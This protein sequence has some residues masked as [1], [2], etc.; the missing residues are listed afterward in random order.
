MRAEHFIIK[1]RFAYANN[2]PVSFVAITAGE[3]KKA[4]W[5]VGHG[6]MDPAGSCARCGRTLTH[7]GSILIGIGPE[8]LGNWGARDA[9]L[10]DMT[11]QDQVYLKSLVTDR[12]VDKW[13]PKAAIKS[14][15]ATDET[16]T[17]PDDHRS[18]TPKPSPGIP[19]PQGNQ[20]VTVAKEGTKRA[21]EWKGLIAIQFPYSYET[22][23]QVKQ[24]EGR[25]YHAEGKYWTAS[26]KERSV[27]LL[28]QWGFALDLALTK[29]IDLEVKRVHEAREAERTAEVQ[30]AVLQKELGLKKTLFPFQKEGVAFIESRNGR[31]LIADEM[32]LGK[33]IQALAY[34][35]LHPELRPAVIICPASLKLNWAKEIRET[36]TQATNTQILQGKR[37]HKLHGQIVIIN[38]DILPFWLAALT[39]FE[40]KVIIGDEIHYI[41]SNSA[42]R[43]KAVKQLAKEVKHVLALSGTPIVNRPIEIFNALSIISP[44]LFAFKQF[45]HRYCAAKFNGFG[46]DFTGATNTEE[47]HKKLTETVMIRRKK[48][49]VLKDLP[50]KMYSFIPMELDNQEEY[51]SIESDVI[52]YLR[53]AKGEAA[54]DKASNAEIIVQIELLKQSAVRGKLASALEWVED[55]LESGEK[56]VLFATHKF[57]IDAVMARFESIAVKIDGS[58]D[59]F[60]RQIAVEA[61]QQNPKLKLFVGNIKAAGVGLTLTAA[62]NVAFIEFPWTPGEL[63]QAIDRCHRIGQK[64]TVSVHYLMAPDTI[65]EKIAKLLDKK[66]KVLDGVLDGKKTDEGSLLIE[67]MQELTLQNKYQLQ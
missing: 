48:A 5:V 11:K 9:K 56:L 40:P 51:D 35:Q 66:T 16:I 57:V 37:V 21:R 44:G 64:D 52:G 4:I 19:M 45:T 50:D 60:E 17:L 27:E 38:Y 10:D 62:S 24:L 67:L 26:I 18:L 47:L 2:L 25:K 58:V 43:T 12:K 46:W 7:P 30:K 29:L 65:D 14:R 3:T 53:T 41:K 23:Q 22:V 34:L 13:I 15:K 36:M 63:N 6:A 31:V 28:Q 32:G 39:A 8:C 61:F 20:M 55:F 59:G 54:A 49:D 33:T 1:A 42:K